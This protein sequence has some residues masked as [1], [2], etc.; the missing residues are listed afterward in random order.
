M[1]YLIINMI[2]GKIIE[3]DRFSYIN[4]IFGLNLSNLK[5]ILPLKV[6]IFDLFCMRSLSMAKLLFKKDQSVSRSLNLATQLLRVSK[7]LR[8]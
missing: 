5:I 6:N 4:R 3:F 1:N 2:Y 8:E 7:I